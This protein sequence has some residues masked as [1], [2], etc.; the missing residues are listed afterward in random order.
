MTRTQANFTIIG[1]LL[2]IAALALAV[3][4]SGCSAPPLDVPADA[5]APAQEEPAG[6]AVVPLPYVATTPPDDAG[7]VGRR[8]PATCD[9]DAGQV[10]TDGGACVRVDG[11][12]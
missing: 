12:A 1:L 8:P 5:P 11:G 9:T 6:S 3:I 10:V 2:T 4:L 7:N